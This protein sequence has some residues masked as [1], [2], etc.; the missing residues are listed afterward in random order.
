MNKTRFSIIIP[1]Y[2]TEEKFLKDCFDSVE[3]QTFKNYEVIIVDDGSEKKTKEFL[4]TYA[5]KHQIITQETNKGI[6]AGRKRGVQTAKGE[7]VLF[8]DSDDILN[9]NALQKL[10][11]IITRYKSDVIIFQTPKFTNSISECKPITSF[12]LEDGAIEKERVI[13]ELL[14]LHI[15]GIADKVARRQLLD[16][17]NDDLDESIINGEDLQQSTALILKSESFYYTHE[18][19]C[20]YRIN[21]Q[22][23]TYYDVRKIHD[24]NYMVPPY[25]MVFE[26]NSNYNQYLSTYKNACINSIIYNIFCIYEAKLPKKETY[27][28]LDKINN[29]EVSIVLDNI[30]EKISLPSQIVFSLFRNRHYFVLSLLASIY[31]LQH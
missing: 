5:T 6:V 21:I 4:N 17:T 26:K 11:N 15:N 28:L 25:R 13:Q 27:Q 30:K 19:I 18:E 23:R 3:K 8:L 24:I 29:L 14:K 31:P 7:Y 20:Y 2:N 22:G 10:D 12:F 1:V 16:F 9:E